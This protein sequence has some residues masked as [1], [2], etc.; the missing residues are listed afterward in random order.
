MPGAHLPI[1]P[2]EAL[3]EDR[4]DFVLLLAWNFAD[5]ILVQQ[6]Q[7]RR[8]GGTFILP[9]PEPR[10]VPPEASGSAMRG[11]ASRPQ[12]NG[13]CDLSILRL[14]TVRP[15]SRGRAGSTNS[16]TQRS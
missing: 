1:R 8:G 6:H 13:V 10:I 11:V 3:L 12:Q 2:T 5:E 15:L 14:G 4:P 7:Y 16:L 9:I